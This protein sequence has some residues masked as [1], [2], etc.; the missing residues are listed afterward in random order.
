MK[1]IKFYSSFIFTVLICFAFSQTNPELVIEKEGK[2]YNVILKIEESKDIAT[3]TVKGY[4]FNKV[5]NQNFEY[6]YFYKD[7]FKKKAGP[8]VVHKLN[9]DTEFI[10]Y[11]ITIE[12]KNG[13]ENHLP[14]KKLI[15]PNS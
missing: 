14:S 7:L 6:K 2:N 12:K 5:E 8:T 4:N 13:A 15:M 3:V 9:L 10:Y 11:T 1:D